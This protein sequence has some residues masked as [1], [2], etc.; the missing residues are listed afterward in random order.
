M[1]LYSLLDPSMSCMRRFSP[2][3]Q[4]VTATSPAWHECSQE[5]LLLW[6]WVE[7]G[8]GKDGRIR[9][10]RSRTSK[11]WSLLPWRYPNSPATVSP[12]HLPRPRRRPA[13]ALPEGKW[14]Q[15]NSWGVGTRRSPACHWVPSIL[16]GLL[17]YWGA[18]GIRGGRGPSRPCGRHI[19]RFLHWGPV[20]RGTQRQ[21]YQTASPGVGQGVFCGGYEEMGLKGPRGAGIPV[22]MP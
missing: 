21:S 22:E 17:A 2:G 20:C 13:R 4:T 19:Y 10:S 11:G 18:E 8:P 3:V 9:R 14:E 15:E 12:T 1:H 5:T 16:Q 6:C 7:A